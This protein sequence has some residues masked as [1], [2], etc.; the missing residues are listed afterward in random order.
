MMGLISVILTLL[1]KI[2]DGSHDKYHMYDTI[3]AYLLVFFKSITIII[4]I[5]GCIKTFYQSKKEPKIRKFMIELLVLGGVYI[6]SVPLVMVA[7]EY[8]PA[9]SRKEWVFIVI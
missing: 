7:V 5:V 6:S 4:F 3:P 8:V 1:N 2:T 9:S